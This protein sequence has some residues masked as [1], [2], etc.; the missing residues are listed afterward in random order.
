MFLK[1]AVFKNFAALTGKHLEPLFN[2]I[3]GLRAEYLNLK[4][5]SNTGVFR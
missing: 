5:N 1:K 2:K 3:V 4:R